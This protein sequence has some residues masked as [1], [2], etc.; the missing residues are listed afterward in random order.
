VIAVFL[1]YTLSGFIA[2]GY[3]VV[4]FRIFVDRFGSSNLTFV[5][6]LCNFIGGLGAGALASRR[7]TTFLSR[8]LRLES[9]LA[10]C[11]VVEI[12]I[13]ASLLLTVL[14][15]AAPL[16]FWGHFPYQLGAEGLYQPTLAYQLG[17]ALFATAC[18]F[19]PCFFMGITFP[20]LCN[21]FQESPRF[22]STL[23]GWN[24]LGACLGVLACE[25]L[26]LPTIGHSRTLGVL[27]ALNAGLAVAFFALG[28]R[29]R[30]RA[31]EPGAAASPAGAPSPPAGAHPAAGE[32]DA[33]WLDPSVV[34]TC[35][36]LSGLLCGALEADMFRRVRLVG[37]TSDVSMSFISLWAILGIFLG[38]WT[39]RA[40]AP[41]LSHIKIAFAAALAAYAL[42]WRFAFPIRDWLNARYF[43]SLSKLAASGESP[44][45]VGDILLFP[46]HGSPLIVLAFTGAF[47][48]LTYYLVS[49]LL[50]TVCNRLQGSG[51]HLGAAYGLNTVAFCAGLMAFSW[52]APRVNMFYALRLL[53]V[54]F[55]ISVAVLIAV[56][57]R[58]P[59]KARLLVAAGAAFVIGALVTPRSFA[60][61]YFHP[62]SLP[63][64][65]PVR[66]V[67][68]N[69]AHTTYVVRAP[70]G[71]YLFFDGH[72]MSGTSARDQRHMRLMA[73]VPLL[74]N[75]APQRALLICFGVGNTAAAIAAHET[76]REI[77]IVELNEKVYE[78]A[79]EFVEANGDVTADPRMRLIH[80]D[81]RSFLNL[82]DRT[83]DLVTSD[84]PPPMS[85]GVYRLYSREYYA[86]VLEHLTPQGLMTQWLPAHQMPGRAVELAVS[87]FVSVF[88]HA[89]AFIGYERDVILVGSGAPIDVA[90]IERRFFESARVAGDLARVGIPDPVALLARIVVGEETIRR[91]YGS[92]PVVSDERN[93]FSHLFLEGFDSEVMPYD[94]R[95]VLTEIGA[96]RLRG[97]ERLVRTVTNLALL[98]SVV[99]DFPASSLLTVRGR[100]EGIAYAD[101]DWSAI[102]QL[103]Q[104]GV[105]AAHAGKFPEAIALFQRSLEMAGDQ[106]HVLAGFATLQGE[107]GNHEAALAAWSRS[108]SLLPNEPETLAGIARSLVGLERY[109]EAVAAYDRLIARA[110]GDEAAARGREDAAARLAAAR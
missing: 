76:I 67:K 6:V 73:H 21:A 16:G 3:Q 19:V 87:T 94:P 85:G 96:E 34:L 93:E 89:L 84:P 105:D 52:I 28:A 108:D 68:S 56:R 14:F 103:N 23:Y 60:T 92:M 99:P 1:L 32:R 40:L 38:S 39:V 41:R 33:G 58:T 98:K 29:D 24:T 101:A 78:T 20:L 10:V 31:P 42:T 44:P 81:G 104:A 12:L 75:P 77:D 102:G 22:P 47:V 55:A 4:W 2:L 37:A 51:R 5:L 74:A 9:L 66:A 36:V 79:S 63:A 53:F 106:T 109:R 50:P 107:M 91:V 86:S 95:A 70:Y 45:A 69:G 27:M 7:I 59:V 57:E 110:P 48:F 88:P 71:D 49:L 13:T 64:R 26:F 17:K 11:G 18:V 72:S 43:A 100:G 62:S 8:R 46:L 90:T 25:F 97:G 83:Y 65:Y 61:S 80:D 54:F 30:G 15:R 35:A 82:T